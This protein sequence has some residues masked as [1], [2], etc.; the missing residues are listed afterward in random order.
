MFGPPLYVWSLSDECSYDLLGTCPVQISKPF[1]FPKFVLLT[2]LLTFQDSIGRI[3]CV[4]YKQAND[5]IG[6]T[7]EELVMKAQAPTGP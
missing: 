3:L 5:T 7:T 1:S 6:S 2:T 4:P